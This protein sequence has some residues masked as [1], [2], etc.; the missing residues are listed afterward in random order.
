MYGLRVCL[1][2]HRLVKLTTVR[3]KPNLCFWRFSQPQAIKMK[4]LIGAVIVITSNHFTMLSIL[5]V[6]V[7]R[8]EVRL[9]GG[10]EN[11][12]PMFSNR[13]LAFDTLSSRKADPPQF[14][15]HKCLHY[16]TQ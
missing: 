12:L 4:P 15:P 6:A 3:T 11:H 1:E 10:R 13:V 5:T 9:S 16:C 14:I 2:P 7:F 8:V